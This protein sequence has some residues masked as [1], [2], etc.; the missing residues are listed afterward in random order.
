RLESPYDG[1]EL[2]GLS[3]YLEP[4]TVRWSSID[5]VTASRFI[6]SRNG[7]FTGQP[8]V[9]VDNPAETITLPRL[10]AGDYYWTIRAETEGGYDIGA[11]APRL[12]R[13]LPIPLLPAAGGR[14]PADGAVITGAALRQKRNIVFSWDAVPGA[15]GYLFTIKHEGTGRIIIQ[16]GL[17]TKTTFLLEDLTILDVGSF[18]WR[19]EAV[20]TEPIR[21]RRDDEDEIIQHGKAGEN[22]FSLDF[23]LP[24]MPDMQKPG[25]LY[26]KE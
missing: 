1:A 7:D 3:A 22:R 17:H 23:A 18:I 6:L 21:E 4:G 20:L 9:A 16:E 13:V 2:D 26:G 15:N 5:T 10:P 19:V 14:L 24:D 25:L 12:L 11:Q 8:V